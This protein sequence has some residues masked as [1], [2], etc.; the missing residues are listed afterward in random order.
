[1]RRLLAQGER[2]RRALLAVA[3]GRK[4]Q[5]PLGWRSLRRIFI[6]G[7][8]NCETLLESSNRQFALTVQRTLRP[9]DVE[10]I[11]AHKF[12]PVAADAGHA[13]RG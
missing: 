1:L 10:G 4:G 2:R 13:E 7:D 8:A 12:P 5:R 6:A 9:T 3:H 11:D